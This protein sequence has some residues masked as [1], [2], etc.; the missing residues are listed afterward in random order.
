MGS[1]LGFFGFDLFMCFDLLW[2]VLWSFSCG[3][4][5]V[6]VYCVHFLCVLR[7]LNLWFFKWILLFFPL[8]FV[9]EF[10]KFCFVG[11][12]LCVLYFS[13]VCASSFGFCMFC[14]SVYICLNGLVFAVCFFIDIF[15]YCFCLNL[16]VVVLFIFFKSYLLSLTYIE[17]CW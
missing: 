15:M 12:Y 11:V 7:F 16:V 1:S 17:D 10:F 2:D 3:F 9:G 4:V 8:I 13:L 5:Y 14:L 6:C